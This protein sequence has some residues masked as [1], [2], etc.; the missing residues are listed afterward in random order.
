MSRPIGFLPQGIGKCNRAVGLLVVALV[1]GC[2]TSNSYKAEYLPE[3]LRVPPQVNSQTADLSRLAS[4]TLGSDRISRGDVLEVTISASLSIDDTLEIPVRVDDQ[5]VAHLPDIGKVPIAGLELTAAEAVIAEACVRSGQYR[6][7]YVTVTMK[8]KKLN[9]VTVMG[10]VNSP[11]EYPLP[12]E[13]STLL[14]AL[15]AADG[16]ADNAGS[17]VEVRMPASAGAASQAQAAGAQVVP[18]GHT[19]VAMKQGLQAYRVDLASLSEDESSRRTIPDRGVVMVEKRD[20]APIQV[21][22]L[23]RKQGQQDY[24]VG[25]DLRLLDAVSQAGGMS[26]GFADKILVIRQVAGESN[27]AVI[28]VSYNKAKRSSASNLRLAPGDVVSVEY[29]PATVLWDTVRNFVNFGFNA[30]ARATLL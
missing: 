1:S 22:G 11:G 19:V 21:I 8:Q 28:K 9:Y 15:V 2:A 6:S 17:Y 25:R 18:A 26:S 3:A 20:P 5:G 23:V 30:S 29:T 10:A 13:S 27:P 12:S 7:P 14:A 16:L 24:P 4:S